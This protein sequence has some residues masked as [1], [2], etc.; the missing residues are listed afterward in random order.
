MSNFPKDLSWVCLV[1]EIKN[2]DNKPSEMIANICSEYSV[3]DYEIDRV[4]NKLIGLKSRKAQLLTAAINIG[5]IMEL[6]LPFISIHP[7]KFPVIVT[8]NTI[9]FQTNVI[10]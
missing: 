8:N 3:L 4:E 5:K 10:K 2:L 1:D 9:S 6:E 7:D